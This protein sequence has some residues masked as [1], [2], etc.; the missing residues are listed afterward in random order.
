MVERQ[1]D[2]ACNPCLDGMS[3]CSTYLT[4]RHDS[5]DG[6]LDPAIIRRLSF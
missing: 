1:Q 3:C 2:A 4:H 6:G 5:D